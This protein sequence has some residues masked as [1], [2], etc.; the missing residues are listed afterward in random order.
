MHP[1]TNDYFFHPEVHAIFENEA[2]IRTCSM[3][4]CECCEHCKT[5]PKHLKLKRFDYISIIHDY[6]H[7]KI[8]SIHDLSL[9]IG[10]QLFDNFMAKEIYLWSPIIIYIIKQTLKIK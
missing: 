8:K 7:G 9:Y 3:C 5:C 6:I 2:D 10:D 4:D 1:K